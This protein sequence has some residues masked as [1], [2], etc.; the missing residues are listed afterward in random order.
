MATAPARSRRLDPFELYGEPA[1]VVVAA[2]TVVVAIAVNMRPASS[3]AADFYV[4]WDSARWLLEGRDIY[5]AHPLRPSA[6]DNLNPPAVT[7]LFVPF[8][9]L[10]LVPSFLGWTVLAVVGFL[11]AGRLVANALL[12]GRG[13][14]IASLILCSQA[15]F[16]ALQLGQLSWL[17]TLAVTL[18]WRADRADARWRAGLLLGC[19][20]AAKPFLGVFGVYALW[21][22]SSALLGGMAIG[23][24]AFAAAGLAAGGPLAYW[25]WIFVLGRVNWPAHLAN[26]SL[27]G[28]VSRVLERQTSGEIAIT[29]VVHWPEVVTGAWL[30]A[31]LV[32]TVLGAR[33]IARSAGD[34]D[35]H[36]FILL[37]LSLLLSP[38]G[39]SYYVP[40]LSGPAVA[41]YLAGR[42]HAR[43]LLIAGYACF[44]VPYTVLLRDLGPAG[45]LLLGSVYTWGLLAW[46]AATVIPHA[47]PVRAPLAA[48]TAS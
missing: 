38:L 44:L 34:I 37:L 22:R 28:I 15:T 10:P 46:Y 13:V 36:W 33:R 32:V 29:P 17:L 26:G 8:A 43:A 6:G 20:M 48:A 7:L 39:W 24:L 47:E 4:F 42:R 16:A 41:V 40:L 2:I 1:L 11:L 9:W 25:S 31:G 21:R 45:T 14:L 12:P 19:L 5:L 35:Q 23:M 18:A 3:N 27:L 30:F